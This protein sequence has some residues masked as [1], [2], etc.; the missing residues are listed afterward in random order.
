M[1][2][3]SANMYFLRDACR[4]RERGRGVAHRLSHS[5]TLLLLLLLLVNAVERKRRS[6]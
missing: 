2:E 6:R 5:L 3:L 1:V 4:G